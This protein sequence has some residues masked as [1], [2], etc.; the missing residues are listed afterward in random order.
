[1]FYRRGTGKLGE[2]RNKKWKGRKTEERGSPNKK[3]RERHR[4][5]KQETRRKSPSRKAVEVKKTKMN[6]KTRID[7]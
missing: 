4:N 7:K 5:I 6:R 1:M 2:K 3:G